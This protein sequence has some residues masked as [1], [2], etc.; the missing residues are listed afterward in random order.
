MNF[1]SVNCCEK[2][3]NF[4]NLLSLLAEDRR[5]RL[6][7]SNFLLPSDRGCCPGFLCSGCRLL[8][9]LAGNFNTPFNVENHSYI[10][11]QQSD[12]SDNEVQVVWTLM[13]TN[14]DFVQPIYTA[15]RC[16]AF[17]TTLERLPSLG[18]FRDIQDIQNLVMP[19][20]SASPFARADVLSALT[21]STTDTIIR[22]LV[23]SLK[24]WEKL[25]FS[26]G[27]PNVNNLVFDNEGPL[28]RLRF[29]NFKNSSVKGIN[30][31]NPL[32]SVFISKN[33][34]IISNTYE[35]RLTQPELNYVHMLRK[36]GQCVYGSSLDIYYFMVGLMSE[37]PFNSCVLT[38]H[39]LYKIWSSMWKPEEFQTINSLIGNVATRENDNYLTT[40][41][42]TEVLKGKTMFS[43]VA[44]RIESAFQ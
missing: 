13:E 21:P 7:S 34:E 5:S 28:I 27:D 1:C 15:H 42:I 6:N 41:E 35:Y 26:H 11:R 10:I 17:M 29:T 19:Y 24:S 32:T 43:N 4:P 30:N 23:R 37:I 2:I 9:R 33:P 22:E 16:G 8:H 36:N 44:D 18:S 14:P 12:I 39:R 25:Q 38:D 31:S 3:R 20:P 40:D